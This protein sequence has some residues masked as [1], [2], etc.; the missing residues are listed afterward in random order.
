MIVIG[1]LVD[2]AFAHHGAGGTAATRTKTTPTA[3]ADP[4]TGAALTTYL[5]GRTG[6]ATAAVLDLDT[7]HEWV[8]HP[9]YRFQTASIVKADIL[10][11]LLHQ[12]GGNVT[13]LQ[14]A[15]TSTALGMIEASNND[16]ASALWDAIGDAD[17]LA[18]YNKLAGLTSTTPGADGYWG[19]T[20]TSATDQILLLKQLALAPHLLTK[21]AQDYQ[22]S[23]MH[24]I[25][26]GEKWGVTGGVPSNVSV[27]LKNGWVPLSSDTDWEVNSIGWVNGDGRDYLIAIL[28]AHEPSENYGIATVNHISSVVYGA[29][30]SGTDGGTTSSTSTTSTASVMTG[31]GTTASTT[32]SMTTSDTTSTS[33]T[34]PTSS[35]ST[36]TNSS[37]S[38]TPTSS[39][40]TNSSTATTA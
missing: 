11:T 34:T 40:A 22:L 36:A 7:G 29:F 9:T 21:A 26:P 28:T 14:D 33:S 27:A 2:I 39:A 32:A 15:E 17:G 12:N 20:L 16:D 18:A 6:K 30:Q 38:T 24:N 10:E 23:L 5:A 4:L 19:E 1:A 37:T 25:D 3:A 8:L 35:T 31:T 13:A